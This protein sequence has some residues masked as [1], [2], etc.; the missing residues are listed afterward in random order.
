MEQKDENIREALRCLVQEFYEQ[1]SAFYKEVSV[2]D[3]LAWLEEQGEQKHKFNIGDIISNGTAV[4]RVDNIIKNSIRQDCYFLV[5]VE[6]EKRGHRYLV[7][8]NSEGKSSNYGEITWLCEQ[9]DK[10]F[11]KQGEQ[12][13]Y[14]T[15]IKEKA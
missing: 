8:T 1:T 6:A 5:N 13:K 3:M 4:Y 2:R 9:V 7:L 15:A 12:Y 10:L 11:E 14:K